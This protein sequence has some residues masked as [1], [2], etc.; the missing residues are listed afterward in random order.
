MNLVEQTTRFSYKDIQRTAGEEMVSLRGTLLRL[1]K[2]NELV[3]GVSS[4][5]RTRLSSPK[6]IFRMHKN[7]HDG[8]GNERKEESVVKS[9]G[10]YLKGV[11]LFSGD[12]I[13]GEG[14]VR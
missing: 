3:G 13:S 1:V 14:N 5:K 10:V 12:T 9:L 8:R 11:K 6:V 2:L 7:W 4:P